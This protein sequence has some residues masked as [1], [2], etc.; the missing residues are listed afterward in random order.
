LVLLA[1]AM[2]PCAE[3]RGGIAR[4]DRDLAHRVKSGGFGAVPLGFTTD[5]P[6]GSAGSF[7]FFSYKN[8]EFSGNALR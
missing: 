7:T 5:V 2:M 4:G 8:K 1:F 3:A 6:R